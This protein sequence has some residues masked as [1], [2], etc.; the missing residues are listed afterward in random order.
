MIGIKWKMWAEAGMIVQYPHKLDWSTGEVFHIEGDMLHIYNRYEEYETRHIS[1]VNKKWPI[2]K[3]EQ[4]KYE[5][6]MRQEST[7]Q[8]HKSLLRRLEKSRSVDLSQERQ[9]SQLI[10]QLENVFGSGIE[11]EYK[12]PLAREIGLPKD[13]HEELPSP[14][15]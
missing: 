5:W 12:P 9:L 6:K 1:Q 15:L 4:E 3:E 11:I 8:R 14:P 7:R 2:T 13:P 10:T